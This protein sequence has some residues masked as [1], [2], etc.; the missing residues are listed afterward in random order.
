MFEHALKGAIVGGMMLL[1]IAFM[2]AAV[3][4]AKKGGVSARAHAVSRRRKR[5]LRHLTSTVYCAVTLAG[6]G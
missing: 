5:R 4:R 3:R 6:A 1:A 2:V